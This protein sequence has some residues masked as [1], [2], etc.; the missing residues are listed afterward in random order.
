M[1]YTSYFG[2]LKNIPK[3]IIPVAI[4]GKCP[5]WYNGLKYKK[6]APKYGFFQ[7]YK[8]TGDE[9]Y[10]ISHYNDEVLSIL[11]PEEVYSDLMKLT[12]NAEDIVLLCYEK[13]EDFC[14][15]HI[16][17]DWLSD[18]NIHVEEFK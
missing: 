14:H 12:N 2:K 6:V 1:I 4:C 8:K 16:L 15:R 9:N 18:Y 7:E 10:Y 3:N 11:T 5:D 13:P 17:A